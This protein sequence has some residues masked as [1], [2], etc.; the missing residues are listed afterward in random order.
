MQTCCGNSNK[1]VMN[2]KT[3]WKVCTNLPRTDG[4]LTFPLFQHGDQVA[5]RLS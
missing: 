1:P 4:R 5:V 3:V 2:S